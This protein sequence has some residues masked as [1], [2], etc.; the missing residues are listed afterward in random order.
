MNIILTVGILLIIVSYATRKSKYATLIGFA[1]V[2]LIMGFQ[3][4][5]EGDFINYKEKFE[6]LA[7]T[8][9]EEAI[10]GGF[11]YGWILLRRLFSFGPFWLFILSISLFQSIVLVKFTKTY[12]V[13]DYQYLAAILF[14]FTFLMMLWQMKAIR[15]GLAIEIMLLAFILV[16]EKKKLLPPLI[17]AI[18]AFSIHNTSLI[19]IPFLV[20]YFISKKDKNTTR[21]SGGNGYFVR[22]LPIII[23]TLYFVVYAAKIT[24]LQQ[25]LSPLAF[26]LLDDTDSRFAGYF[27]ETN[28]REGIFS[29]IGEDVSLLLVLYNAIIVFVVS[30]YYKYADSKM[31]V[32]SAISIIAAFADML[33]FGLGVFPRLFM[34]YTAF[35][36]VVYPN[37]CKQIKTSYGWV[38]ALVFIVLL[39]G[40]AWK[41]SYP[42]M[43]GTDDGRFGTYQFVFWK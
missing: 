17:C 33:F 43:I 38:F 40:Y 32:F 22:N 29:L 27:D 23:T 6:Q 12:C 3:N 37:V 19:I 36:I 41:S 30:W 25:Y 34:Y 26:L 20:L 13:K 15:Q 21:E 9:N 31:R 1:F 24:F 35:N 2:F 11:E 28:T 14:Y 42:W 10:E 39:I 5:V 18:L 4:G 8:G 7:S 16:D